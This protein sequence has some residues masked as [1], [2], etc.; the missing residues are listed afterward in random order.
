VI[1]ALGPKLVNDCDCRSQ[2][3]FCWLCRSHAG[4]LLEHGELNLMRDRIPVLDHGYVELLDH[5]GG[6]LDIV[7]GARQ[8]FDDVSILHAPTCP[9]INSASDLS[10]CECGTYWSGQGTA[11]RHLHP[12]DA[13]LINFLMREKHTSPFEQVQAKFAVQLP[14]FVAREWMRHRTQSFNE[15][16]GRYTQLPRLFYVPDRDQIRVQK[17]KPGAYYYERMEDDVRAKQVQGYIHSAAS[18]SFD[19][20][21]SMLEQGVAKEIARLVLPV[22]TYTKF[23]VSANLLNWMRFLS[24]RNHEHAQYEINVYAQ[25]IEMVLGTIAPKA[26]DAF[27]E[28]GRLR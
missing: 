13:G 27:V 11:L 1:E 7:N 19:D 22:N 20:Y 24:L 10:S 28:H 17:G 6:D 25:A 2:Q 26:M 12:K 16:S 23:V 15:M 4:Y 8:S 14:I 3:D 9:D 21:E 18:V 5:M